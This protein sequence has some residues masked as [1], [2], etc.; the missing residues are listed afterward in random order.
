MVDM[1]IVSRIRNPKRRSAIISGLDF[2]HSRLVQVRAVDLDGNSSIPVDLVVKMN[3]CFNII[4]NN[5]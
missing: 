1:Q 4:N 2:L 5:N 3:P